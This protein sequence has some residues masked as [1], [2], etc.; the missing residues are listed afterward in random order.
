MKLAKIGIKPI[1]LE[2]GARV[3]GIA[4]TE[5]F[6]GYRWTSADIVSSLKVDEVEAF[7]QEVL[8]DDFFITPALEPHLLHHQFIYIPLRFSDALSKLGVGQKFPG[9]D[10]L[11]PL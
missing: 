7:W 4:R 1:V 11:L 8:G 10:E 2:M 6:N 5:V 9:V 3:G